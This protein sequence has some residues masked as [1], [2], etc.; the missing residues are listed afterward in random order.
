MPQSLSLTRSCWPSA[1]FNSASAHY[2]TCWLCPGSHLSIPQNVFPTIGA[3]ILLGHS[4]NQVPWSLTHMWHLQTSPT[5]THRLSEPFCLIWVFYSDFRKPHYQASFYFS[6]V[7]L[8]EIHILTDVKH[9][10]D[11][12]KAVQK[13]KGDWVGAGLC[14]NLIGTQELISELLR[15]VGCGKTACLWKHV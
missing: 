9:Q 4:S 15:G 1:D 2:L 10:V 14:Y 3:Y 8:G 11:G 12:M 5:L 7:F 6:L 13:P